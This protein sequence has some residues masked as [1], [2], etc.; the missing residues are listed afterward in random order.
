MGKWRDKWRS[1]FAEQ[2]TYYWIF[3]GVLLMVH[4]FL[5]VTEPMPFWGKVA[6]V[7]VPGAVYM[8][9][10][11]LFRKP[12]TAIWLLFPMLVFGA[13]QL[14][15][16][17][18]FGNSIIAVDMFLNVVTTNSTEIFEL[19][20]KLM[21]AIIG[22]I[23]LYVPALYWGVK[24]IRLKQRLPWSVRKRYL[25]VSLL[26][27]LVGLGSIRLA[28]WQ[29]DDYRIRL[30]LWPANIFYNI[31]K[32]REAWVK[33][34]QYPETSKG[35][36]FEAV[37]E[38][39]DSV[40]EVYILVIGE[41]SRAL[42]WQLYGYERPTTPGL[43]KTG[44]LVHFTDFLTQSNT[45]HKS[46]PIMLSTASAED[47]SLLY[48]QRSLI[49]AFKEA[50]FRTAFYSN[51]RP[52]HSYIDIFAHEADTMVFLKETM[53]K[54][55]GS[56]YDPYDW[57][58]LKS[59]DY[60]LSQGWRKQLIVLHTYGSHFNYQERYDARD[61]YFAPDNI[62]G[63]RVSEKP[64]L[65]N[66]YDNSIRAT[67]AL[68]TALVDRLRQVDGASA[69]FYASDHGEDI[70]DDKRRLF[71]HASPLPSYYQVHVPAILWISDGY[72]SLWPDAR[73]QAQRHM[74][75]PMTSNVIFHTLLDLGGIGTVHRNDSLSVISGDFTVTPRHYL[76]DH[77]LPLSLDK[78]GF[79]PADLEMFEKLD[80]DFPWEAISE[81]D[82]QKI[83]R[84]KSRVNR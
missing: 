20:G 46:V 24:S 50:G 61:A 42:N 23:V 38:H 37:S 32:A 2:R 45:T 16:L 53:P 41:T 33:I 15:L 14:V 11:A 64:Q 68:L 27:F 49:T 80:L 83:E 8:A 70:L 28:R 7:L 35:F 69:L 54:L 66:A 52:N 22:V 18:L 51:Q 17:Y 79:K 29:D 72:D 60:S 36:T 63:I 19:L 44:G 4:L 58:M 57:E 5:C 65:V 31:G 56:E 47:Y 75:K 48:T 1:W 39:P 62:T 21:P 78:I 10:L 74:Q 67:D 55:E 84:F 6:L 9:F 3:L 34:Q 82:K 25:W 73:K 40:R 59:V 13:F 76:N 81:K 71:L 43:V 12:G 30:D 26:I 77:N